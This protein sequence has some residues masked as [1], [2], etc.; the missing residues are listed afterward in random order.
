MNETFKCIIVPTK[1]FSDQV[2]LYVNENEWKLDA[3]RNGARIS[4]GN[5][6]SLLGEGKRDLTPTFG[7]I[8]LVSSPHRLLFTKAGHFGR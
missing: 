4:T 5:T 6:W 2:T 1:K 7:S 8:P 3:P